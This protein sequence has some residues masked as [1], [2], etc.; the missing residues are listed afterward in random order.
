MFDL[1]AFTV[2]GIF[3]VI[4]FGVACS[5]EEP[6]IS[7]VIEESNVLEC[8]LLLM[9]LLNKQIKMKGT[10][11]GEKGKKILELDYS[12]M[13]INRGTQQR[14]ATMILFLAILKYNGF[15]FSLPFVIKM[16]LRMLSHRQRPTHHG[17]PYLRLAERVFFFSA[18]RSERTT[19]VYSAVVCFYGCNL[20]S[21]S[22]PAGRYY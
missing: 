21:Q 7:A 19:T 1:T 14:N 20:F 9:L 2:D 16:L 22:P 8:K 4:G 15:D 3:V 5:M 17:L 18:T 10:K 12:N 11:D 13:R 6:V